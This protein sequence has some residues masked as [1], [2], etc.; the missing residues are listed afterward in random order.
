[1]TWSR[2]AIE[3]SIASRRARAKG[4]LH[5]DA[6]AVVHKYDNPKAFRKAKASYAAAFKRS[7]IVFAHG[8]DGGK[9]F[10]KMQKARDKF[11]KR[12]DKIREDYVSSYRKG[13]KK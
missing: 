11:E 5:G 10:R 1:M 13:G 3:A 6:S 7:D 12:M 4:K 2:A 9:A 8:P